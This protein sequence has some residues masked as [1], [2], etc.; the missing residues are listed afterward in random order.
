MPPE[1]T[2]H[3]QVGDDTVGV[4]IT[5]DTD[6]ALLVKLGG[7]TRRITLMPAGDGL[8]YF[9]TVDGVRRPVYAA[10][11]A[12]TLEILVAGDLFSTSRV[13]VP[14]SGS[15]GSGSVGSGP[16]TLKAPMPGLVKDVLVTEGERVEQG[17]PLLV[18][19]AMKMNNQIRSPRAGLVLNLAVVPG[20][21]LTRGDELL[22]LA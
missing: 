11:D 6:G 1:S 12:Q 16:L 15:P 8:T 13:G 2:Y 10:T 4:G 3:I 14:G 21:R 22:S 7:T 18:L 17:T 20:Q 19:E 9:L 5:P